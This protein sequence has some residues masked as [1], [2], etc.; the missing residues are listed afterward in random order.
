MFEYS[1]LSSGSWSG[2]TSASRSTRRA[3]SS[4][5]PVLSACAAFPCSVEKPLVWLSSCRIV[6]TPAGRPAKAIQIV[7]NLG[8]QVDLAR[9]DQLHHGQRREALGD[10]ADQEGRIRRDFAVAPDLEN[11]VR[12]NRCDLAIGH[13]GIGQARHAGSGHLASDEILDGSFGCTQM[14]GGTQTH[15]KKGQDY[16][17]DGVPPRG[18]DAPL[19]MSAAASTAPASS[20]TAIAVTGMSGRTIDC[21]ASAC[22]VRSASTPR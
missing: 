10:R 13:D 3:S 20:R 4:S 22:P 8:I 15:C 14:Q 19:R 16:V 9:L 12:T 17:H 1:H 5:P 6:I 21:P 18:R 11:A 7:G 2:A